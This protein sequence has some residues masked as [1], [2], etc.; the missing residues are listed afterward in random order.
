MKFLFKRY[1]D[2]EKTHGDAAGVEHVKQAAK[3]YVEANLT[4][5]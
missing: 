3:E 2:F 4:E 5:S 1:L